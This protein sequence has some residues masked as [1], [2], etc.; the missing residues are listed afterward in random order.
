[1]MRTQ[2]PHERGNVQKS[3]LRRGF[4]VI[5]ALPRDRI[6]VLAPAAERA[7]YHTFW[8]NDEPDGDG[9]A[10]LREAAAVTSMIRLGVGV[11]PLDRQGPRQIAERIATLEL[12]VARLVLG[13]GSGGAAG[14]ID[15]VRAGVSALRQMVNAPLVVGAIGPRLCRLAGEEA[16]GLLLDWVTPAYAA[17]TVA[18]VSGA[19]AETGRSRPWMASYVFT[20]L[21]PDAIG[22]LRAEAAHYAAIPS[23]AAHFAR[24]GADAMAAAVAAE[25]P[26]SLRRQLAAFDSVLDET[27]VRAVV[28][29]ETT[30]AYLALLAA[31]A[32]G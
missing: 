21:G 24:M 15:R 16:D 27:V 8:V 2:H 7:G 5:G 32:P 17:Q 12:P 3:G 6:R 18:A 1:M 19:A 28:S 11:I 22:K 26:R 29:S 4:G 30:A 20:A 10:A 31:A 14:G 25:E 23:Y 13:V 9:L